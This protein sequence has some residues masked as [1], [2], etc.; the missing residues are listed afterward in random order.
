MPR[1]LPT[2]IYYY[3]KA[4]DSQS[5]KFYTNKAVLPVLKESGSSLQFKNHVVLQGKR[6]AA[7]SRRKSGKA[8]MPLP[9]LGSKMTRAPQ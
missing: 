3:T 4:V 5:K 1:N 2:P 9:L 8:A 6:H 7:D